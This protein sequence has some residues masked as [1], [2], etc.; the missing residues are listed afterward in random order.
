MSNLLKKIVLSFL[1]TLILLF[2]FAPF[3]KVHA[4]SVPQTGNWYNQDFKE[5]YGKVYDENISPPNEIFGERYTA[6]QVEW[7]MYG[8]LSFII[9]QAVGPQNAPL[10]SCFISNFGDLSTCKQLLTKILSEGPV[11]PNLAVNSKPTRSL[12]SLVFAADRPLSGISYVKQRLQN[13]SII[14][15]AKAQTTGFGFTALQPIQSAWRASRDIAFGLF[16]LA[17]VILAFMVMFRVKISPQLAISVQSAIPKLI[18]ALVLVT[19]S[20][21]IAGLMIDF[22]YVII[23]ILS[24]VG[25]NLLGIISIPAPLVFT[26]L[27]ESNILYLLA[28][29]LIALVLSFI[30]L[31][32]IMM[33]AVLTSVLTVGVG[34]GAVLLFG[35]SGGTIAAVLAI[36]ALVLAVIIVIVVAWMMIRT[37]WM[38]IKAFANVLL[39]VIFGP[40]QMVV[41]TVI[42]NFGFGQWLRSLAAAL[43]TFVVTGALIL[44]AFVFLIN[45]VMLGITDLVGSGP[46]ANFGNALVKGLFGTAIVGAATGQTSAAWPPLLGSG[47][48]LSGVGLLFLGVSFVLFTMIPKS[49]ELVAALLSGKPFAYGSGIGEALA[50]F[51]WGRDRV[52]S[53]P[54]Y[55][56]FMEFYGSRRAADYLESGFARQVARSGVV[57]GLGK[58]V[59]MDVEKTRADLAKGIRQKVVS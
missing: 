18:I 57:S 43:S 37:I 16:V 12:L 11:T 2:S 56:S 46:T 41:G 53:S 8:L 51:A 58:L 49:T 50:P 33:G 15:V 28:V 10:T 5:W 20:Y 19:F 7:V 54:A 44:F 23:G 27:T 30:I 26:F 47:N 6:A 4:Q 35:V 34:A 48:S 36:I 29:Y 21:A 3:L 39:L 42:P 38:L 59:G 25:Q 24:L 1:S 17:A 14:P 32:G 13:F 45:G 22:M 52:T 55:R 9:N 31:I 40:L